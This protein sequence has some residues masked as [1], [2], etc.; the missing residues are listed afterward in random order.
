MFVKIIIIIFSG[1]SPNVFEQRIC[2]KNRKSKIQCNF[3]KSNISLNPGNFSDNKENLLMA[4]T[5]Q[6]DNRVKLK[7]S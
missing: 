6:A 2:C 3:E 1:K 4:V 7:A 5:I